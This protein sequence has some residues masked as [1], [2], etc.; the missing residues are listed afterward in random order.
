MV[1]IYKDYEDLS[2]A[3][4]NLFVRRAKESIRAGGKFCVVLSG[5]GTPLGMYRCLASQ[6]MRGQVD[7]SRVHVFWS[8]E[9]CTSSGE[10][11]PNSTKAMEELLLHV[12]IPI[13][14]VHPI[15]CTQNPMMT[16]QQYERILQ[17][18][19]QGYDPRF[20]LIFLGLGADAHTASLFPGSSALLEEN[21]W[22]VDAYVPKLRSH[23]V[24][25]TPN[26]IN[27]A[28]TIVFLVSGEEK[29]HALKDVLDGEEKPSRLPAQLIQPR[30]GER[31]WM[32]DQSAAVLLPG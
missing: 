2:Q 19:F 7:W 32:V 11:L 26:L 31:I 10:E 21:R 13:E 9:H 1:E 6:S 25:L 8:D 27:Q 23:R 29:S 5:G 15:P 3:A 30:D 4:A 18:F 16:A 14:Q 28:V 22:V 17:S 12:P 20:D 24:T